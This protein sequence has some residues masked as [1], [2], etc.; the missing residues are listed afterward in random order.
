MRHRKKRHLRGGRDRRRHELRALV[1]AL[2]LYEKIETTAA[3][4]RLARAK[5]ERLITRAKKLDLAARRAILRDLPRQATRKIF[6]VLAPRYQTRPGGYV[7][8]AHAGHF[9]DGTK[10]VLLELIQ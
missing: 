9:K 6:E 3:R 5:A 1:T 8:I 10:K 7:R 2:V 4:A